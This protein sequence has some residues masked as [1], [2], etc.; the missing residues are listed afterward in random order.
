M[1]TRPSRWA[2]EEEEK[3]EEEVGIAVAER[4]DPSVPHART[5]GIDGRG[6]IRVCLDPLPQRVNEGESGRIPRIVS[7]GV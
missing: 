4:T 3:E 5:A 2:E 6:A 1:H 7:A